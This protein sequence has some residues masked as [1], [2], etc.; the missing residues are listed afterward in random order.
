MKLAPSFWENF[1]IPIIHK[2]SVFIK[3]ILNLHFL[4]GPS[5]LGEYFPIISVEL[6]NEL[7]HYEVQLSDIMEP[8]FFHLYG[9]PNS[10]RSEFIRPLIVFA[11]DHKMPYLLENLEEVGF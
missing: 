10:L 9:R 5:F 1:E 2:K 7:E 6:R 8:L 3:N 11:A 4:C